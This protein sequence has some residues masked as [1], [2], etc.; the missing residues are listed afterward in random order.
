MWA[1]QKSPASWNTRR[2]G[3]EGRSFRSTASTPAANAAHAAATHSKSWI[4]QRGNGRAPSAAQATT[5][6]SMRQSTSGR[7]VW[8]FW[9]VRKCCAHTRK[10]PPD[11][12]NSKPA[13][14]AQ[15]LQGKPRRQRMLKQ[16]LAPRGVG[17][18][19][20][21]GGEEVNVAIYDREDTK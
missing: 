5:G 7:P 15:A 16:E 2:S 10:I 19:V 21:Q 13:E 12:R 17:I 1:G 8:Q 6:T 4:W 14:F 11:W 20:L 18:P 3:T 9:P